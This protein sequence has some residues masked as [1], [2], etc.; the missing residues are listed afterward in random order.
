MANLFF[1][2]FL[3]LFQIGLTQHFALLG[4]KLL[5]RVENMAIEALG[6]FGGGFDLDGF[7]VGKQAAVALAKSSL[8][9]DC[10]LTGLRQQAASKSAP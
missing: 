9:A 3:F 2:G 10:G 1:L 8:L 4:S 6:Y 7:E 5:P